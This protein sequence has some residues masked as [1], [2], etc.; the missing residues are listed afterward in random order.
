MDWSGLIAVMLITIGAQS[1][2]A[3][4]LRPDLDLSTARSMG[5][6]CLSHAAAQ[7]QNVAVAIFDRAGELVTFARMDNVSSGVAEVAKWKGRSA[8]KYQYST[9]E[10][11]GWNVPTAPDLATVGGGVPIFDSK[12]NPLGGV[13]VSGASVEFDAACGT[14][15]VKSV[16]LTIQR[17]D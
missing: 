2:S 5:D 12:G 6:H 4:T 13:G 3:Q 8:A 15:A 14:E 7:H 1:A 9:V 17:K 16:G 11:A 10:T